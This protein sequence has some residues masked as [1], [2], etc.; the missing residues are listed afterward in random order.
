MEHDVSTNPRGK[1]TVEE[2]LQLERK[3]EIRSEYLDGE[4]FAM[5]G[6]SRDHNRIMLNIAFEFENQLRQTPCE[7]FA[8]EMR[9]KVSS[10]GM[11]TY[12][13]LL[14]TCA[15]PEFEDDYVDTLTNPQVIV[16]VLSDS[17]ESYDRGKKFAHYRTIPS[18]REYLLVSQTECR[19]ERFA[20][21]EDDSWVFSEC[22]D[23]AGS[24]DLVSVPCQ[25]SLSRVYHKV[26][27]KRASRHSREAL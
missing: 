5:S 6:V 1:I 12:P 9:T 10:S 27:F 26:D 18:L 7:I 19:I 8:A 2:Y 11:Y 25:L 24:L 17:T 4:M 21:Q 14:I 23:P 13:D 20:R 15:E 3:A 16:E 22:T